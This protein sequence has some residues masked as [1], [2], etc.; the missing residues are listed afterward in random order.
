MDEQTVIESAQNGNTE[1]LRLLFE[2]NRQKIFS[3]AYQYVKNVE[4]AEDILQ[5]TFIKA[6]RSL[7]KFQSRNGT[8]FSPWLYRIGINCS[9]D[10]LRR[11]KNRRLKHSDTDDL[12]NFSSRSGGSSSEP[13]HTRDRKEI[14]EKIDQT[15]NRL[16]GRQKM[17]FILKHYQ[18]LT[19]AEIAEYLDC[20][21]GSVK[22][23]LFRAVQ[24]VKQ[25]L[26]GLIMEDSY[27]MQKV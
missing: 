17:I 20:S 6:Y 25:H 9:I 15:L 7:D 24:T 12:D 5:E 26:K 14:R 1:A 18:E 16:S 21:E 27:E 22:R 2:D 8:R 3:L 23:Q 10:Y 19:T 13:E 11:N 4:D